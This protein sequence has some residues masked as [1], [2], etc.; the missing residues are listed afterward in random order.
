MIHYRVVGR[1]YTVDN[2]SDHS[3]RLAVCLLVGYILQLSLLVCVYGRL[4]RHVANY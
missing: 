1:L 3:R 2:V 4:K